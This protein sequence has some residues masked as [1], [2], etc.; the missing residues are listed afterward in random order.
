MCNLCAGTD[1]DRAVA[2]KAHVFYA[3]QMEA[4]ATA[5]RCLAS[6]T[7]NPHSKEANRVGNV[8]RSLIR[9]LVAEWV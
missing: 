8:A 1:E 2:R 9:E 7:I 5:Y 6:G 4:L 3:E